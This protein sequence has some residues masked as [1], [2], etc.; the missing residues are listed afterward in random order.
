MTERQWD[1]L[2]FKN[3]YKS[4]VT[5]G[6]E[7]YRKEKSADFESMFGSVSEPVRRELTKI[8]RDIDHLQR[9]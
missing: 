7:V 5:D 3:A 6:S 9:Q 2:R 8:S 1:E 4:L